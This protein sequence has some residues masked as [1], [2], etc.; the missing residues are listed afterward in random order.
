MFKAKTRLLVT[1]CAVLTLL[2]MAIPLQPTA[3]NNS[4]AVQSQLMQDDGTDTPPKKKA[5]AWMS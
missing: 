1:A 2:V 4:S 3:A 5:V